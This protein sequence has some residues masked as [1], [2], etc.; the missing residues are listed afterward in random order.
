MSMKSLA[1]SLLAVL[2]VGL[3]CTSSANANGDHRWQRGENNECPVGL[4][5]KLT[6]DDEFGPGSK[7]LTRCLERRHRVKVVVQINKFCRDAAAT[8]AA[9]AEGRAYALGN[10]NNM[11]KDYET[12][13]GMVRGKD[14]EIVAVVHSGGGWLMLKD[15]GFDGNGDPVTGRNKF[16][17]DVKDLIAKGVRFYFCQNTT[18]GFVRKGILPEVGETTGGATGE[19]IKGVEYT[20]AGVT[21]I[22]EFQSKGYNY[23]QP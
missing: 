21:A 7:E 2:L 10:I 5:N 23:V 17:D 6:L 13:H 16:D 18:R 20:T 1:N 11:I 8:V 22:A 12:T 3:G 19:L 9:C 4:V 15:E 14:Y